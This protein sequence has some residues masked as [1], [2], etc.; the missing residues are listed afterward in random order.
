MS[1]VKYWEVETPVVIEGE[2]SVAKIYTENG[3]VQVFPKVAG[4]RHGI[5][6]G[7]TLCL[8]TMDIVTLKRL[9]AE[10]TKAIN[11]QVAAQS[12]EDKQVS[13]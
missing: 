11:E 3:K 13:Q 2:K 9:H 8:E 10:I 7:A 5:G 12:E 1:N 6:R 4:T